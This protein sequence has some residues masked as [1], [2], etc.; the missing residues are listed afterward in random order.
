MR[1]VG[2]ARNSRRSVLSS[3]ALPPPPLDVREYEEVPTGLGPIWFDRRD[4]VMR[5][6]VKHR[7]AWE[8]N[9]GT[10][11]RALIKPGTR[12]LDVGANVGYFSLLAAGAASQVIIDAVEPHPGNAATL[13]WNLWINRVAATVHQLALDD[14]RRHL[15]L[16]VI[17]TNMGDVRVSDRATT[18]D[19]IEVDALAADELFAGR[20]FDV[21]KIDVQGWE[22]EVIR[23]MQQTIER[24]PGIVLVAEFWPT[25]L[26]DRDVEPLEVLDAY[27]ALD[28]DMVTQVDDRLRR[29]PNEQ[30]VEIC[31]SAGP[32][33][34]VNVLLSRR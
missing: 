8:E 26:R 24:S 7:Q 10:L 31:D 30:I 28:L 27:R 14:R 5:P 12:F 34:Q 9:E 33:G 21:V 15:R 11:L 23:G 17:P 3:A 19:A 29:L 4:E 20:S 2:V 13:R 1:I 18:T 32:Y 25:A 22:P 6:Y 16:A